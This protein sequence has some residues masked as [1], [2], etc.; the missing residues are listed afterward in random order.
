MTI[1]EAF[2]RVIP[3]L[4]FILTMFSIAAFIIPTRPIL[5]AVLGLTVFTVVM[6]YLIYMGY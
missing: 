5:G 6:T 2:L 3:L 4:F 1:F